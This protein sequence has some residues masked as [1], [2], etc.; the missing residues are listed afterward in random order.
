MGLEIRAK[1][2]KSVS[3][4]RL[5]IFK[6]PGTRDLLGE[7]TVKFWVDAVGVDRGG[8][9]LAQR[10]LDRA[11]GNLEQSALADVR[12]FLCVAL[13]DRFDERLFAR[14]ILVERADAD[15]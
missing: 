15:A 3:L 11:C 5:D 4:D 9:E 1:E 12:Q 2:W 8:D 14:K 6:S 7:D 13:D 10:R